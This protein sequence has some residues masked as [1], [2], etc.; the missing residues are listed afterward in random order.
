M[1]LLYI[2]FIALVAVSTVAAEVDT[3]ITCEKCD[4]KFLACCRNFDINNST[5]C[6]GDCEKECVPESESTGAP[7]ICT[8]GSS[9]MRYSAVLMLAMLAVFTFFRKQ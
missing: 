3:E 4:K 5:K 7:P 8:G 2:V 6:V 9:D 1:N